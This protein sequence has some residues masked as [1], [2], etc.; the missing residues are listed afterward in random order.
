MYTIGEVSKLFG[1]PIS[2]LRFYD[3]EGLFP[4]IQRVS[5]IRRFSETELET[6]RVI[7]CLKRS[8][9]EIK[10]INQFMKWCEQ[11]NDTLLNRKQLFEK[12][13]KAVEEEL[14]KLTEVYNMIQFKCWYYGEALKYNNEDLA[15]A[16][17]P[18]DLPENVKTFYDISH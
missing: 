9:L 3:K 14:A 15:S 10:D 7:N 13:K 4:Y 5:G 12:Q 17:I 1:I 2:T 11:G 6:L 16:K 18:H 8:G